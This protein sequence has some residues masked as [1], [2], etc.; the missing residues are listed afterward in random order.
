[1]HGRRHVNE[2]DSG[3]ASA[4]GVPHDRRAGNLLRVLGEA[5]AQTEHRPTS[6]VVFVSM[7]APLSARSRIGQRVVGDVLVV[8]P[9][10]GLNRHAAVSS[11]FMRWCCH[12]SPRES[13]TPLCE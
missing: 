4:L 13:L 5:K 1:M 3:T 9:H 6:K 7:N 2:L 10:V 11:S 12:R 8:D